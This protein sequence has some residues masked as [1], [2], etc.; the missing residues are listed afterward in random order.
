METFSVAE[1]FPRCQDCPPGLPMIDCRSPLKDYGA[2]TISSPSPSYDDIDALIALAKRFRDRH[3][4][5]EAAELVRLGLQLDPGNEALRLS[6]AELRGQGQRQ[7]GGASERTL[8]DT[9]REEHRRNAIDAAQFLGLATLYADRGETGRALECLDVARAKDPANPAVHKLHGQL[10]GRRQDFASAAVKLNTALRFNPFDRETAE[11]LGRVEY[12]RRRFAEALRA[13]VH[14]FLLFNEER[15]LPEEGQRLRRRIRTLKGILGYDGEALRA[16]FRTVRETLNT[17]LDRL[18]WQRERFREEGGL[19]EATLAPA[20]PLR[21]SGNGLIDLAARLRRS[22][23]WEALPDLGVIRIADSVHEE[24]VAAGKFLFRQGDQGQDLYLVEQGEV[25]IQRTTPYG[26][27]VLRTL[28][29]GTLCGE[30][31]FL[32]AHPRDN[33]AVVAKAAVLLRFD[34][35]MLHQHLEKEPELGVQLLWTFWHSLA[36]KLRAAND[37]LRAFAE[38]DGARSPGDRPP[39][40][41]ETHPVVIDQDTKIRLFREQG[42]SAGELTTL[43]TFLTERRYPDAALLFQEG[44]EGCEMFIILEGKARISKSIEGSGEEALAILTRGDFFGEMALLDGEPRSA[45]ARAHGGP[46]TVLVLNQ[47]AFQGIRLLDPDAALQFLSLM[48]RLITRRLREI[49]A[50][51]VAWRILAGPVEEG[52]EGETRQL[53]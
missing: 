23:S 45:D 12:E 27:H 17:A 30:D 35:A 51:R 21:P 38:D 32:Q 2:E 31:T 11:A 29:A 39:T 52:Q 26:D 25:S 6:L 4:F 41:V 48:C 40:A 53:S 42:L 28:G 50:K 14:A 37:Q 33:D 44:E 20:R 18:E 19:W 36:R 8:R 15:D 9:V 7:P 43:A 47:Q 16:I 10:R 3:R 22:E 24:R 13:T 49:D 46:L 34:H 5:A 1:I